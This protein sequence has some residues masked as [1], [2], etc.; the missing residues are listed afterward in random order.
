MCSNSSTKAR[1]RGYRILQ[2]ERQAV[3]AASRFGT[4]LVVAAVWINRERKLIMEVF[5]NLDSRV[6]QNRILILLLLFPVM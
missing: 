2:A 4:Y 5:K 6:K 3:T 1:L